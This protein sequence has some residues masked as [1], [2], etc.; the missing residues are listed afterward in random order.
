MNFL[1]VAL[2]GACGAVARYGISLLPVK[3]TFPYLTFVTNISGAILIGILIGVF[4]AREDIG[5][6]WNLF[7]KVGVCGGFTTFS[8]FSLEAFHLYEQGHAGMSVS[9][10]ALSVVCCVAAVWF[11]RM[12]A[13]KA[14]G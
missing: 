8:T 10:A 14:L 6:G 13:T 5:P 1:W 9:Y 11:G 12:L 2:G 7:L 3:T 4:S